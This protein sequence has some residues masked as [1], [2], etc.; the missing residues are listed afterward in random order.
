MGLVNEYRRQIN[1][2]DWDAVYSAL[3]PL[4]G[5]AVLDLGCGVGD[6]AAELVARGVRVTGYD[7]SAEFIAE[8]RRRGL[9]GT[10]FR[11]GDLRHALGLE[12]QVDGIWCSFTAAYFPDLAESLRRWARHLKPG[13][14]VAVTE[15]DDLFGHEPLSAPTSAL[16]DAYADEAF[17]AGRYD[18]RM[19][20][21]LESHLCQAGLHVEK[22]FAIRDKELAFDGRAQPDV[23]EAWRDRF[24]RMKRLRDFCGDQARIVEQEFLECLACD[25]HRSRAKIICCLARSPRKV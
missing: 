3:P 20:R 16:L 2:R 14:W 4:A 22:S 5:L 24:A 23:L 10:E 11:V 8:A 25:D 15:I 6:Q 12:V 1:W 7:A 13:G 17:I 19:G 18:F 9:P 21:K